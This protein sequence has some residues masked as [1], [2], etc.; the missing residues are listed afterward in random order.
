MDFYVYLHKKKTDGEVF[1]I[2]KGRGTRAW[3]KHSRNKFW[4]SVVEKHGHIVELVFEGLNEKDALQHEISLIKHYGRRNLGTGTLVNLTGGGEGGYGMVYTEEQRQD[5]SR[6]VS[7][8]K[9]PNADPTVWT[10]KNL[11]TGE[12]FIGTKFEMSKLHPEVGIGGLFSKG[13]TKKWVVLGYTSEAVIER[14]LLEHRIHTT[15]PKNNNIYNWL[16]LETGEIVEATCRDIRKLHPEIN[17]K[18]VINSGGLTSR[19]WTTLEIYKREG[20]DSLLN[21]KAG[22]NNGNYDNTIYEFVN[23]LSLECFTG[24]R[25]GLEEKYGICVGDLFQKRKRHVANGWCLSENLEEAQENSRVDYIKYLFVNQLGEEFYGTRTDFRVKYGF[26]I[27]P[28]F[29]KSGAPK[30]CKGWYLSPKETEEFS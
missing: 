21:P 2:G 7:G 1:Y 22:K 15:P 16:N 19:G 8:S 14:V 24:S 17:T 20:L 4:K 12:E 5:V 6:R 13:H 3:H 9:N 25:F 30:T 28:L 18:D 23:L 11:R 27:H 29:R 26:K 10:F